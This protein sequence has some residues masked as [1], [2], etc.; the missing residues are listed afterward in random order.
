M[1]AKEKHRKRLLEYLGNPENDFL[2]RSAMASEILKLSAKTFYRH[3]APHEIQE[4]ELAAY[5]ER[6]K[7]S[8]RQRGIILNSLY[9]E[10]KGGN[11]PAA[12]EFLDRTEGKVPDKLDAT[13]TKRKIVI[14]RKTRDGEDD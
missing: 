3:F 11:V 12:K 10:G 9:T 2:N 7:N 1:T 6:K 8:A 4:I 13:V 14:R 5:E